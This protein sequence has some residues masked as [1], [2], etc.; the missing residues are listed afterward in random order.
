MANQHIVAHVFSFTIDNFS[1]LQSPIN[2]P[3]FTLFTGY[4]RSCT[5]EKCQ[6]LFMIDF[7]LLAP[8]LCKIHFWD[9]ASHHALSRVV[10]LTDANQ[11]YHIFMTTHEESL[12]IAND[13]GDKLIVHIEF[14]T[15]TSGRSNES[16]RLMISYLN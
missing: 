12:K 7:C 13:C 8:T 16:A 6:E 2:I 5:V 3:E 9:M 15:D 10:N 14:H 4:P 11:I 1:A